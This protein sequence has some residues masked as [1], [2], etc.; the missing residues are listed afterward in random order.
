MPRVRRRSPWPRISRGTVSRLDLDAAARD[1]A[2]TGRDAAAPWFR[3]LSSEFPCR[4]RDRRP[5]QVPGHAVRKRRRTSRAGRGPTGRRRLACYPLCS[6]QPRRRPAPALGV[7]A[8]LPQFA[9]RQSR[10]RP[11]NRRG[12]PG[13]HRGREWCPGRRCRAAEC[14][15]KADRSRNKITE[16]ERQLFDQTL[17]GDT[18]RHNEVFVGVDTS[19]RSGMTAPLAPMAPQRDGQ[20][21]VC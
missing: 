21:R 13:A 10:P 12:R 19:N 15:E 17:T 2:T 1:G 18:R 20:K 7:G 14:A 11:G 9:Q 3:H 5:R 8:F 4:Q 6:R 16:R